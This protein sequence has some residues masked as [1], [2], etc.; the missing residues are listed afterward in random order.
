MPLP[1]AF[2]LRGRLRVFRDPVSLP[3]VV[4]LLR[5]EPPGR[6]GGREVRLRLLGR[7]RH[8]RV[9][10][11]RRRER[12]FFRKRL[13]PL[14]VGNRGRGLARRTRLVRAERVALDP[15]R[16]RHFRW[17]LGDPRLARHDE[18]ARSRRWRGFV[19]GRGRYFLFGRL[20]VGNVGG[21]HARRP[22]RR[23]SLR[24]DARPRRG[25][26]RRG[27]REHVARGAEARSR[28]LDA[29]VSKKNS[30][31]PR[32][33]VRETD[34]ERVVAWSVKAPSA[35]SRVALA[36]RFRSVRPSQPRCPA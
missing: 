26:R 13:R 27:H 12:W 5:R 11:E 6:V 29:R 31:G 16:G 32:K 17:R 1:A 28:L 18:L 14:W 36:T 23:S 3:R 9:R 22:S 24:A 25:E 21:V 7:L 20:P 2:F 15:R 8:A 30:R 33:K 4:R 35:S 10:R 34:L 19:R